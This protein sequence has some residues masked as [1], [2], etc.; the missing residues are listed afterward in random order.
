MRLRVFFGRFIL[1]VALFS[2]PLVGLS[3]RD[4]KG[5][6]KG[7]D[8]FAHDVR[9]IHDTYNGAYLRAE[10][11]FAV[12][13]SQMAAKWRDVEAGKGRYDLQY[14]TAGDGRVREE[15][16]AM[17]GITLPADDPFWDKYYPPNG[18]RCRCT[19]VEVN[20]GKYPVSDSEEA[21]RTGDKATTKLDRFGNNKAGI[22]RFN[23]GKEGKVF[24]PKHPYGKVDKEVRETVE[25]M[26]DKQ[27]KPRLTPAEK[28]AVYSKPIEQQ[29][30]KVYTDKSSGHSVLQHRLVDETAED[31]KQVLT[32]AKAYAKEGDCKINPVVMPNA[33]QGRERIYPGISDNSNPDLTVEKCGYV[34][35]KSPRKKN[36]IV[37]NANAAC[38]QSATAVITDLAMK[39]SLSMEDIAKFTERIFSDENIDQDKKA[40]YTKDEIHWL[41]KGKLI[42][43]N[44][45]RKN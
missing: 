19:A 3:L 28:D 38:K 30:D 34:D 26:A 32:V 5:R 43:C 2:M 36:N 17:H 21:R 44:R 27:V 16:A 40:N 11:D 6:V 29:F 42:K 15:H 1:D 23:P 31:Y 9:K 13:S 33:K 45:P 37:R 25:A 18:W 10:Y 20:K 7:Y 12:T 39:E 24:P 41:I 22:F 4:D 35:V 8:A 14:R